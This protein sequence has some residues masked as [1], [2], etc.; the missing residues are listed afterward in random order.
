MLYGWSFPENP[1][2]SRGLIY[3]IMKKLFLGMALA[4]VAI[5]FTSCG[6]TEMCY[7]ITVKTKILG[8]ENSTTYYER[9]TKNNIKD[10]EDE[11]KAALEATG[12]S[13]DA[14]TISSVAAPDSNCE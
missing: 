14:I 10:K 1:I 12:V 4:C 2:K 11:L 5:A 8:I 6:D 9:A 13:E 3:R 7:K